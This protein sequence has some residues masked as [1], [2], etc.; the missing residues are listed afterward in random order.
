[1]VEARSPELFE[2]VK[3]TTGLVSYWHGDANN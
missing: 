2:V 3:L 1:M